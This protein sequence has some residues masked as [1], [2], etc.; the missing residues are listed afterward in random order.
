VR[1]LQIAIYHKK[2]KESF[3]IHIVMSA[4]SALL[5]GGCCWERK[6]HRNK[7][8]KIRKKEKSNGDKLQGVFSLFFW[9]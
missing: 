4:A 2:K 9:M 7:K 6:A 8:I 1:P 3:H 5:C